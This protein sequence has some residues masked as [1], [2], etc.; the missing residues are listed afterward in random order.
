M[1]GW[2]GWED[3]VGRRRLETSCQSPNSSSVEQKFARHL[4]WTQRGLGRIWGTQGMVVEGS[5]RLLAPQVFLLEVNQEETV[6]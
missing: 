4:L 3:L 1:K 5:I 6:F 2:E